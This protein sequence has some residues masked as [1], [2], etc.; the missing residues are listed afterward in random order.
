MEMQVAISCER[1][2]A[3]WNVRKSI[4]GLQMKIAGRPHRAPI[5]HRAC[6]NIAGSRASWPR[7]VFLFTSRRD[8]HLNQSISPILL[9]SVQF[10][11]KFIVTL[12][13]ISPKYEIRTA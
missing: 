1:M 2:Y 13:A 3:S 6:V 12:T 7:R 8:L 5:S 10:T 9:A 11:T 4:M